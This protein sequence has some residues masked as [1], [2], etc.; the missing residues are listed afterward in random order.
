MIIELKAY[1][2]DDGK[3]VL[4]T[5]TDLPPGDVEIV[6]TY[7]THE[8]KD[9]EALWTKQFAETPIA[10]FDRLIEQG[11]QGYHDGETDEF[12]PHQEDD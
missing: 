5:P 11:L 10:V 1:I 12:D 2:G 9:D 3:I 7:L 8:E 6:I 4:Q